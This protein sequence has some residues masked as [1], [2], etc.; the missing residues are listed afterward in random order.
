MLKAS[1][2][3][4]DVLPRGVKE[5]NVLS[6]HGSSVSSTMLSDFWYSFCRISTAL[7]L[8]PHTHGRRLMC[9]DIMSEAVQSPE[10]KMKP[11]WNEGER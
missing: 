10:I 3:L 8:A 4:M 9:A 5:G 1:L 2:Q 11:V 7:S 6:S